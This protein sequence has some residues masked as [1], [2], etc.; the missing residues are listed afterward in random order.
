MLETTHTVARDEAFPGTAIN[1]GEP[2]MFGV[3]GSAHLL[4]AQSI[5]DHRR[6]DHPGRLAWI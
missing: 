1:K 5:A 4:T 3:D 6:D 2:K